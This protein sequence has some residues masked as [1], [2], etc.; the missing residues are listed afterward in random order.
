MT[1]M[2]YLVEPLPDSEG[3]QR[4]RER[5]AAYA[6]LCRLLADVD[7]RPRL[8]HDAKGAPFLPQC[9]ELA[10]SI[11]HCRRA[12]AVAV[13][14]Q[15]RVGIDVECRRR[16]DDSLVE[17]VCSP[18]EVEAVR[19]ADDPTMAFLR[20]WTR[21]EAVLKMLRTG[22]QGFGSMVHALEDANVVVEDV[23]CAV[24]DVVASLARERAPMGG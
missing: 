18:S 7:P 23:E 13:S 5:E 9:P 8:E 3:S 16:V 17:R 15:G 1:Y 2:R 10:V 14:S 12:V 21:K 6:L 11:S 19:G 24:P 22:I 4:Q 20:L